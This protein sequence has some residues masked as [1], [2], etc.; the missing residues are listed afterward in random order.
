MT[1]AKVLILLF[2]GMFPPTSGTATVAGHDIIYDMPGVR[3]SLGLCP[4]HNIL[5]DDLTVEEHI[6]FFSKLK[7]LKKEEIEEEIDKYIRLLELV[8]KV[9]KSGT[10]KTDPRF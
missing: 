3:E 8:P 1:V 4:Q 5:F 10:E 7:G 2:S 9:I 6:Y